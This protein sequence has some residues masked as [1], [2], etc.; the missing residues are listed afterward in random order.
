[1][2]RSRVYATVSV[3]QINAEQQVVRKL[4]F[5]KN[6]LSVPVS[7]SLLG[8]VSEPVSDGEV[9][10]ADCNIHWDDTI[11]TI[12]RKITDG[13]LKQFTESLSLEEIYLFTQVPERRSIMQLY[14]DATENGTL[15]MTRSKLSSLAMNMN[16][17]S[18]AIMR[19]AEN[20]ENTQESFTMDCFCHV[21]HIL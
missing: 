19:F 15:P 6:A 11:A 13:F 16:I 10:Y 7:E 4:V 20:K 2:N 9:K 12:K 21:L 14:L 5:G 1:M 17:S 3:C 8:S 18:E